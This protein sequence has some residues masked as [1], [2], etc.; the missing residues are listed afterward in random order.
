MFGGTG[1]SWD[2]QYSVPL[3]AIF[4]L[5]QSAK[6]HVEPLGQGKAA[7]LLNE[8][9]EQAWLGFSFDL[10]SQMR[11]A[12]SLQRFDNIC[13]LIK[14]IPAYLLQLSKEGTFWEEMDQVL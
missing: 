13:D 14:V 3:Q 1:G 4:H 10:E 6:D 11:R 9:A 8:T 7:C 12:L 2:V 5:V